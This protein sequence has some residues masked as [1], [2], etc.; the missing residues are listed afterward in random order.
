MSASQHASVEYKQLNIKICDFFPL[1]AFGC[2]LTVPIKAKLSTQI[3]EKDKSQLDTC[4]HCTNSSQNTLSTN[5]G[6]LACT[7]RYI[8]FI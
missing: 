2:F 6:L 3:Y 7:Y 4:W 5:L 1:D 8:C